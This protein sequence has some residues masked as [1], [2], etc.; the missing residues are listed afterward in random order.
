M[1]ANT[2]SV[3]APEASRR[4]SHF[5]QFYDSDVELTEEVGAFLLQALEAGGRAIAIAAADHL[6][7]LAS[8]LDA[9]RTVRLDAQDAILIDAQRALDG[10]MIDGWPDDARFMATVGAL[11][12][13]AA[14]VGQPVHA[15][16]EMVALLYAQGRGEAALRLEELW[17]RLADAHRFSLFCAYPQRAFVGARHTR[18]FGHICNAHQHVLLARPLR[19]AGIEDLHLRLALA[20]QR[21]RSLED[22]MERRRAAEHQRDAVLMNLP[23]ASALLVGR[24][25][26]FQLAN[27]RYLAMVG[28]A[29]LIGLAFLDAFPEQVDGAIAAALQR[30]FADGVP[31]VRE[32]YKTATTDSSERVHT[33][34]FEPLRASSGEVEGVI[35]SAV[36][37]T[38]YVRAR[39]VVEKSR[40]EREALLADLRNANGAKDRFFAMLG[41]ELRNPLAPISTALALVRQQNGGA[42]D[43][44]HD[45]IERQVAHLSR[46][47]EDLL[48]VSR[49]THGAIELVREPVPVATVLAHAIEA[50]NP[51]IAQRSQTLALGLADG[52]GTVFGDAGRLTQV[53]GNLLNNAAKF[54]QAGGHIRVKA[55]STDTEVVVSVTDN[56]AGIDADLMPRL[57]VLFEQGQATIDRANGGLGIGLALVK[58]LVELHGGTVVASS[59]GPGQ[60]STFTVTLPAVAAATGVPPEERATPAPDGNGARVLLVDDN[61]D[62][63]TVMESYL[64]GLGFH[65]TTATDSATALEV[66]AALSPAFAILDIGLPGMDGY[67]LARALR[68]HPRA[69]PLR[70]FAL[71]G[72]GQ[73]EDRRR[74]EEAG[75]ERHFVKPIKLKELVEALT[76]APGTS[77]S[78]PGTTQ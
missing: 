4:C 69:T 75:F 27:P 25:H 31:V 54:T 23:I 26:T 24:Q 7:A 64:V 57:F 42:S 49:I 71:T 15:F 45:I 35:L 67:E 18:L 68:K 72:Y 34:Y 10:F 17:N 38:E 39:D 59:G 63:L 32:E 76:A 16:G 73:P 70:M 46:L 12:A 11:V 44:L 74:S 21:A 14:R 2:E 3:A 6:A 33:L 9:A 40:I 48:D 51:L 62:N 43:P 41:H 53:F 1:K 29:D 37:V 78:P 19:D 30:V 77:E 65:V 8:W 66:A 60:G 36:E 61:K 56:G 52:G 5:V 20:E 55:V 28:R 50:A 47:V 13:D 58:S 22:E